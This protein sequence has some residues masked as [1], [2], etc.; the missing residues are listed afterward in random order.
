MKIIGCLLLS[1]LLTTHGVAQQD[2][3]R[4]KLLNSK[5]G[6]KALGTV[7]KS[8]R[9]DKVATLKSEDAF[10]PYEGKIIRKIIINKIGFE[11]SIYDTTRKVRS[12]IVGFANSLHV[13][14][15][16]G[17]I[18][19]NL[20][21]RENKPLNPYLL[22]DNE[23][24]LRDLDFILDSKIKVIPVKGSKTMVDVEVTTRDVFSIGFK[25]DPIAI[26]AFQ[27]DLFDANVSGQGQR[28]QLNTLYDAERSP[29]LGFEALYRKSSIGGTLINPSIGYT[30][31]NSGRSFGNE[32]EHAFYVRLDRPLVS[33]YSRMAG[34]IE[35][36]KNYSYNNFD[37]TKEDFRVYSY[38]LED[39]WTGYNMGI[40]NKVN[41]RKRHFVALRYFNQTFNDKPTQISEQLNPTYN[42]QQ[43]LLG[44]LTLYEQNFYETQYVFGFGRTE[45]IPYGKRV[46]LT[47]GWASEAGIDRM[48]A[49]ITATREI[50]NRAGNFLSATAS[51]GSFFS[52]GKSEDAFLNVSAV[53]YSRLWIKH[54]L[55]IR[56]RIEGG[57]AKAFNNKIRPLLTLNT[58]LN[59]FTADSLFGYQRLY[60]STETTVFTKGQL[61]GFR[62][63]AFGSI[64]S[65]VIQPEAN[66]K[67]FQ[68]FVFSLNGGVR[69]RNENLIFGTIEL[70]G[71]YFPNAVEG[72]DQFSVQVSTNIRL[73]YTSTFVRP[74]SFVSYN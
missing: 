48:Y 24:H 17:V 52:T 49:G 57:Y 74:P 26:N 21:F 9:S 41:K 27:F 59:D 22:A 18:R 66:G 58:Q 71:F 65:A 70:R 37:K 11:K 68:K 40:S 38:H 25:F 15:R 63:A 46:T 39:V 19:D 31:I 12:A 6:Q 72:I 61:A 10:L 16:E 13:D 3:T 33:P 44:S 30:Q 42:N 20:F 23:R 5:L 14:S 8:N 36:S 60:L 55:K 50:V 34:G 64:E 51:A 69:I 47:S 29:Q 67:L 1:L 45:D 43:F 62:L 53:Y 7:K 28:V 2:T 32:N 54:S 73:K 56:Q 35:V 4:N